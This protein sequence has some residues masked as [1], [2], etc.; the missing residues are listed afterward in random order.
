MSGPAFDPRSIKRVAAYL[1]GLAGADDVCEAIHPA[2]EMYLYNL[3]SLK[4][5]DEAAAILYYL[6]GWQI[7]RTVGEI[8]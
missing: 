1:R 4:G 3:H 5:C 8:V 2:D 6:K 7:C